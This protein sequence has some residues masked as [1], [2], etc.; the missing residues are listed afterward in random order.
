MTCCMRE[1]RRGRVRCEFRVRSSSSANARWSG[2][3]FV[4]LS[5]TT[6]ADELKCSTWVLNFEY[7]NVAKHTLVVER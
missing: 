4:N 3:R 2:L 5:F 1:V 6:L 7:V